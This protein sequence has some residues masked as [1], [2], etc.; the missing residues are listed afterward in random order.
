M[1]SFRKAAL[2]AA[3][4][5]AAQASNT[6]L[7]APVMLPAVHQRGSV[8]YVSGGIGSDQSAALKSAM[9][10]YPLSLEFAGKT[11]YGNEYL[12]DVRVRIADMQGAKRLIAIAH[13][14]FLLA[15]LPEGRY[16]VTAIYRG[17]T[18]Q[19]A[20]KVSSGAHVHLLFVWRSHADWSVT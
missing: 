3:I 13:G 10:Q 14:P 5:A 6:V 17:K 11:G 12:S 18:Q 20:V 7:A 9:H 16:K 8:K 19:R 15:S 4:L 2:I 1:L